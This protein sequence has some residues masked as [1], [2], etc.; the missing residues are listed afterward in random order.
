[1]ERASRAPSNDSNV[2]FQDFNSHCPTVVALTLYLSTSRLVFQS[3]QRVG[4]FSQPY[5]TG[6]FSKLAEAKKSYAKR[7]L[8]AAL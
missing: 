1:M 6:L 2:N 4:F 3:L 8:M 7:L 5:W